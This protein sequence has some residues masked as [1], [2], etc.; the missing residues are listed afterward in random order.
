MRAHQPNILLI[1]TDQHRYDAI[2]GPANHFA[3]KTPG[4]D[5]L[6]NHGVLFEN[7]YTTAPICCPARA[8]IV[9]GTYP[10]Q[11]G[12]I[13]NMAGDACGPLNEGLTTIANRMQA[14]GYQT[15]YCGKSHLG[16]NLR[17]YGFEIADENS[18]DADILTQAC[19]YWRNR[20]WI[21]TKRPFFMVVNFVNPHDV[22]FLDPDGACE[23]QLPPWPNQHDTLA[24]K[25]W[26]QKAKRG[27]EGGWT[28]RRWEYYR[29]FYRSKVEKVD[30][31]IELLLDELFCT[32][33]G[34]S[35]WV[36]ITA[37]HG[38]MA[39]EHGLPF[40]GAYMYDGVTHVPLIVAPPRVRYVGWRNPNP[41]GPEFQ[42]RCCPALVSHIDLAPTMMELAG[43]EADPD[44][45]GTSL[46]PLIEGRRESVRDEAFAE[47]HQ[48]G[49]MVTPIRMVRTDRWK[50]NLYLH[51]GE[52]LYDMQADP[53][54]LNNL[55]DDPAHANVKADLKARQLKHIEQTGDKFF[56]YSVTDY[57]GQ[58]VRPSPQSPQ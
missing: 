47:W 16:G 11:N 10:S 38:D 2:D 15:V 53:A 37:D 9:T 25:P 21:V 48:M 6:R 26:P 57:S 33:Y 39:G 40:K 23:P 32:G 20:D 4:I 12:M 55:A 34:C 28:D 1:T 29:Q 27:P 31:L 5:R 42:P 54:E 58:P 18:Y 52:E 45:P 51:V 44:L 56:S 8:A 49:R 7:A 41:G 3:V 30:G 24:G 22:Y 19:R 35:T 43:I 50:Y 14:A 13:A 46:M 17:H 36:F